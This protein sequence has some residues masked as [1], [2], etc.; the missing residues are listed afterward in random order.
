MA[1]RALSAGAAALALVLALSAGAA[2]AQL[3][4]RPNFNATNTLSNLAARGDRALA[5]VPRVNPLNDF[6]EY[7][8]GFE[9]KDEDYWA[10][11]M[12]TGVAGY[13]IG[14][15]VFLAGFLH[16]IVRLVCVTCCGNGLCPQP[17]KDTT[18]AGWQRKST[19]AFIVFLTA[20]TIGGAAVLYK[21]N[22][23]LDDALDSAI[24]VITAPAATT[25]ATTAQYTS[26]VTQLLVRNA[27][28]SVPD[29]PKN[30]VAVQN[31]L[32]RINSDMA[33]L[34]KTTDDVEKTFNKVK[35]AVIISLL[36]ISIVFLALVCLGSV[37]SV[38]NWATMIAMVL[39]LGF[40]VCAVTWIVFGVFFALA[41]FSDDLCTA[42]EEHNTGIL[43]GTGA[44]SDLNDLIQ[45][46]DSTNAVA[47][48][49]AVDY[50]IAT[51]I[52]SVNI[53]L[54]TA[55]AGYPAG[56]GDTVW[57]LCDT[58]LTTTPRYATTGASAAANCNLVLNNTAG[59]SYMPYPQF[60]ALRARYR[61]DTNS[62]TCYTLANEIPSYTYDSDVLRLDVAASVD[63]QQQAVTNIVL[64]K[65][66]ND[67]YVAFE[68]TQC[69]PMK[70]AFNLVWI[71]MLIGS[72]GLVFS[73][74]LW[75]VTRLHAV[76]FRMEIS[77]G[78]GP[79]EVTMTSMTDQKV[80]A[81]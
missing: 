31:S 45:C 62:P 14:G 63:A 35:D 19:K 57:Q 34:V 60:D 32:A 46:P 54:D 22:K 4:N 7:K 12:F 16:L 13:A 10:S 67:M 21:G 29:M 47:L 25:S 56:P 23:D 33:R 64:C 9:F 52:R 79:V 66:V 78:P 61:C 50:E 41:N 65:P 6:K 28:V 55:N 48:V 73:L 69:A 38:M 39:S 68:N 2:E 18:Y 75:E 1:A 36:V 77:D 44:N 5:V 49:Q 58:K 11:L 37:A 26:D 3:L 80:T 17:R 20:V 30:N 27:E 71:G 15:I 76:S 81:I 51:A 40:L 72:V 8:G 70:D 53:D 43:L 59:V 74:I 42:L 24:K